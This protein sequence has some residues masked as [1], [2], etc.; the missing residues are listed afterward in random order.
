MQI[1]LQVK[2]DLASGS[3]G[4]S[5]AWNYAKQNFPGCEDVGFFT[6]TWMVGQLGSMIRFHYLA[7]KMTKM[8]R[9]EIGCC[10]IEQTY[11]RLQSEG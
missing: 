6:G 2:K 10:K 1:M 4:T 7:L 5:N 3:L 8:F 11:S 9:W